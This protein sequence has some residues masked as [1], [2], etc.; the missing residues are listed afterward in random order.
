[1][2]DAGS[3]RAERLHVGL[4]EMD[5]VR[6]P[7]VVRKPAE[8]LQVLHRPAAEQ[9]LAVL[10]FLDGL[11]QVGVQPQPEPARQRGR[12]RHQSLGG[13][14][15]RA[16]RDRDLRP[17]ARPFLVEGEEALRVGEGRVQVLDE[18]VRREAALR[19][20][21]IH[22]P[23]RGDDAEAELARRLD[24]G[25]HQTRLPGREDVMVVE[26][27]RAAAERQLGE[28]GARGRVL[29]LG[30]HTCPQRVEGLQPGEEVGL[31]RAGA[32]RASGTGG[33]AR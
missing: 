31:L 6:A 25:L 15:R 11:G 18:V 14:E 28:P 24:L 7:D 1:M 33:G 3:G 5:A 9:A 20:A 17:G 12:L 23:A 22:R 4:G 29:G 30:V 13:G 26:D 10:L 32:R 16:G 21:D 19:L 27:R 2:R 8:L